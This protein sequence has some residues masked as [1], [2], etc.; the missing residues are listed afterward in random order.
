MGARVVNVGLLGYGTVGS[1]V[2][3]V[4][5]RLAPSLERELGVSLRVVR[6]LVR[7]THKP[8]PHLP[9]EG[10]LT[11]D[12]AAIRDDPSIE[13]VG[14]AMGGLDPAGPYV[15]ELLAAGK[16]VASANKQ[17]LAARGT[18]L[19]GPGAAPLRFEAAVASA[20]PLVQLLTEAL[21][22]GAVERISGVLNGTTT[23]MLTRLEQGAEFAEALADAQE[24]GY[25]EADPSDDLSGR[26]AAAKI[27]LAATLAFG[28]RVGTQDVETSGI[29]G[30][31]PADVVAARE[32]GLRL[33]LVAEASYD[34]RELAVRVGPTLLPEE[35]PLA[36]VSG[37]G[38][39]IVLEGPEIGALTIA[40]PGAGGPETASA[41][42]SDLLALLRGA[43]D[44]LSRLGAPR[45]DRLAPPRR[46]PPFALRF[47]GG[48]AAGDQAADVLQARRSASGGVEYLLVENGRAAHLPEA[49]L[50]LAKGGVEARVLPVLR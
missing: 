28:V 1:A 35:H 46:E 25:A 14:E 45:P 48:G 7:D 50:A 19:A 33:R 38:N 49:L 15:Q 41:I 8:R 26:D 34:D 27:A 4:L 47:S 2:D 21:P 5:Q 22:H 24:A 30:L 44:Q 37:A 12:F 42:V 9:A 3:R 20:V 29:E 40:G 11:T 10:V 23:Y 13:L 32:L 36:D 17:L 43:P 6:A 31:A 39:H 16:A 18:E